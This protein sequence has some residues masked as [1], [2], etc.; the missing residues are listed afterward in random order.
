ME[1]GKFFCGSF[2]NQNFYRKKIIQYYSCGFG[3]SVLLF[4]LHCSLGL[5]LIGGQSFQRSLNAQENKLVSDPE[6]YHQS[7]CKIYIENSLNYIES[8]KNFKLDDEFGFSENPQTV[9]SRYPS[10]QME[11]AAAAYLLR[12]NRTAEDLIMTDETR[13]IRWNAE[14]A[15]QIPGHGPDLPLEDDSTWSWHWLPEGLLFR[16]YMASNRESRLSVHFV[17]E[18]NLPK[19]YWDPTLGG[20]FPVLRYGNSSRIYPQGFQIDLEA[21]AIA[22]LTLDS[23]RDVYGTDYRFGVPITWR[24]GSLEAKIGYCHISSHRGDEW[25]VQNYLKTGEVT[26]INYVRDSVM[27]GVGYRPDANWR[28]YAGG[29]YAFNTDGGAEPWQLL[30]GAEYSPIMMPG[31]RGSPFMALHLKWAEECDWNIY[32]AFELGW[33]WK[34]VYQHAFR[35]GLYLM[36]GCSD[37]YQFYNRQEKEIGYGIWLDF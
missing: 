1:N 10:D 13:F 5:L 17:H 21:A 20:I 18:D 2:V 36:S 9:T 32:T 23:V 15:A 6:F 34:T 12:G 31:F 28:F 22:R 11:N 3:H 30:T 19:D 24:Q 33:Q 8:E 7:Q 37:Q 26:R 4:L 35:T 16:A 29:D 14:P 25:I 27:F